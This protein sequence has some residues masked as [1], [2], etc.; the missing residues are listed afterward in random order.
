LAVTPSVAAT[1]IEK[2][3]NKQ[4][5][6]VD[7]ITIRLRN[8]SGMV[9]LQTQ[10]DDMTDQLPISYQPNADLAKGTTPLEKSMYFDVFKFLTTRTPNYS[11]NP[12][13]K[14]KDHMK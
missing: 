10:K 3:Y 13:F 8:E 6:I 12:T 4:D 7:N 5:M 9:L 14:V 2:H 11:V 1:A